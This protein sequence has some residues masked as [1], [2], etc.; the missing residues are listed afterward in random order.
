LVIVDVSIVFVQPEQSDEKTNTEL[1]PKVQEFLADDSDDDSESIPVQTF[2]FS[3]QVCT[4]TEIPNEK[5][6][7]LRFC[8]FLE[9]NVFSFHPKLLI[10]FF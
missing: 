1:D 8:F 5:S 4:Q 3:M 9:K 10:F 2:C 6:F 7:F